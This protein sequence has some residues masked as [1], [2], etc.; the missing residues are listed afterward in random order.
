MKLK[1][2]WLIIGYCQNLSLGVTFENYFRDNYPTLNITYDG[3]DPVIHIGLYNKSENCIQAHFGSYKKSDGITVDGT[4]ILNSRLMDNTYDVI[5]MDKSTAKQ[6]NTLSKNFLEILKNKMKQFGRFY[7]PMR[8]RE[9]VNEDINNVIV[10]DLCSIIL[11][12]HSF[13]TNIFENDLYIFSLL[14]KKQNDTL[15]NVRE[16]KPIS[17]ILYNGII[18]NKKTFN[19]GIYILKLLSYD[20]SMSHAFLVNIIE[21]CPE[22]NIPVSMTTFENETMFFLDFVKS[23]KFKNLKRILM[24]LYFIENPS[25]IPS[26][27]SKNMATVIPS[28]DM[29]IIDSNDFKLFYK[30]YTDI[31]VKIIVNIIKNVILKYNSK[32]SLKKPNH[33]LDYK[34]LYNKQLVTEVFGKYGYNFFETDLNILYD[35]SFVSH[36]LYPTRTINPIY[37]HGCIVMVKYNEEQ[38]HNLQDLENKLSYNFFFGNV[39]KIYYKIWEDI[40]GKHMQGGFK[41][42]TSK[43]LDNHFSKKEQKI[44]SKKLGNIKYISPTHANKYI[45]NNS[46]KVLNILINTN[47]Y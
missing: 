6:I 23:N 11:M 1:Q 7:Y 29:P 32:I 13:N 18:D 10:N 33:M 26:S 2:H 14:F 37:T 36:E 24:K 44:I 42:L 17:D 47:N 8:I 27:L 35:P 20:V 40:G 39:I 3:I 12:I 34:L 45:L 25:K 31:I 46:H 28:S 22:I 5:I 38:K 41:M 15:F 21:K 19:I 16:S 30:Y 9:I 4:G 43:M